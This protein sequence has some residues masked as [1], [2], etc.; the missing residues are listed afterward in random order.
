MILKYEQHAEI[1]EIEVFIAYPEKNKIVER[2]LSFLKTIDTRVECFTDESVKMINAS[3]IYYIE[4]LDKKTFAYCE[5]ANYLIKS[6][7][8]QI[9]EKLSGSSFVQI[10]K[11]CIIN[12][13]KLENFTPLANSHLMAVLTNGAQLYVTRKYIAG[14]MHALEVSE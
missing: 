3:D 5:N 14:L 7:L 10:S 4:S 6:R 9:N 13:N 8:Y 2:I 11:Y 1:K 12:I